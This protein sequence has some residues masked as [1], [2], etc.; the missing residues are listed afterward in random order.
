[1]VEI[2]LIHWDEIQMVQL[3][4]HMSWHAV[5]LINRLAAVSLSHREVF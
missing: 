5:S 4:G 3:C 2:L 1:M